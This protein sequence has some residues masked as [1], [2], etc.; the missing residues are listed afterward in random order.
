MKVVGNILKEPLSSGRC[1]ILTILL[2]IILKLHLSIENLH[3]EDFN[4]QMRFLLTC[5]GCVKLLYHKFGIEVNNDSD[6]YSAKFVSGEIK[7]NNLY[8]KI[9]EILFSDPGTKLNIEADEIKN[10]EEQGQNIVN[11]LKTNE[12]LEAFQNIV[13]KI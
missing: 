3:Q 9:L 2:S 5:L 4:I 7:I 12:T 13:E 1:R 10:E 11:F 8:D 6:D